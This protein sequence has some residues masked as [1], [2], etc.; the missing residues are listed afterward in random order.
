MQQLLQTIHRLNQNGLTVLLVEQNV[1]ASLK[2]SQ[3]AYVLENGRIVM[4][5]AGVDLLKTTAC[6]RRIS[7]YKTVEPLRAEREA[8]DGLIVSR[9][10]KG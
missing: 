10:T 8:L 5:G 2:I 4:T 7:D 9:I 3:R 6:A 1:A